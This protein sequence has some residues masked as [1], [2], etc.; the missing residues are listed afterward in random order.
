MRASTALGDTGP[1][2]AATASSPIRSSASGEAHD[3][4]NRE[5]GA[6]FPGANESPDEGAET[7][8]RQEE[9]VRS[10]DSV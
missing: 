10:W 3:E 2:V 8:L 6:R 4:S 9:L 1:C 5:G 7:P